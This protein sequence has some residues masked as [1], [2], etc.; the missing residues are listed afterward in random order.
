M[1]DGE[2]ILI[3]VRNSHYGAAR[4]R[5]RSLDHRWGTGGGVDDNGAGARGGVAPGVGGDAATV[6]AHRRR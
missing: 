6:L 4:K 3:I 2:Q 1:T 5:L